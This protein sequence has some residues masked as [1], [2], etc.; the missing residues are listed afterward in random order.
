MVGFIASLSQA[1]LALLEE[2][3]GG[4]PISIDAVTPLLRKAGIEVSNMTP[5]ELRQLSLSIAALH[6]GK[7]QTISLDNA[8]FR[9]HKPFTDYAIDISKITLEQLQPMKTG[10]KGDDAQMAFEAERLSMELSYVPLSNGPSGENTDL[11]P[12]TV[13]LEIPAPKLSA[14]TNLLTLL[15]AYSANFTA[16]LKSYVPGQ[17]GFDYQSFQHFMVDEKTG[18]SFSS[19]TVGIEILE[20]G[21]L[22]QGI[23]QQGGMEKN[24]TLLLHNPHFGQENLQLVGMKPTV[25]SQPVVKFGLAELDNLQA[26]PMTLKNGFI[27]LDDHANGSVRFNLETDFKSLN[28]YC[29]E[30]LPK[31]IRKKVTANDDAE[32]KCVLCLDLKIQQGMLDLDRLWATGFNEGGVNLVQKLLSHCLLATLNSKKTRIAEDR[33]NIAVP[34]KPR[35]DL[36]SKPDDVLGIVPEGCHLEGDGVVAV[37][38]GT[39]TSDVGNMK[40]LAAFLRSARDKIKKI[41]KKGEKIKKNIKK[42]KDKMKHSEKVTVNTWLP[43]PEETRA[44]RTV[45][46]GRGKIDIFTLMA[47]S[48]FDWE[49]RN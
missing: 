23:T 17:D 28:A 34:V 38:P 18:I 12:T 4:L 8:R 49:S 1:G 27:Y 2:K 25:D 21:S 24:A 10:S 36:R 3:S 26:G 11:K 14:E 15:G 46:G 19:K 9:Y 20:Y 29:P 33:L 40:G 45:E 35:G 41:D 22:L 43:I 16:L 32:R 6:L 47:E 5:Q 48:G 44:F 37:S 7:N 31:H 42:V 30:W 39:L 13:K